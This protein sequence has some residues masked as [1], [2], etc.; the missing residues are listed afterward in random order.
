MVMTLHFHYRGCGFNLW[1]GNEDPTCPAFPTSCE[2][3]NMRNKIK[4]FVF[5][6]NKVDSSPSPFSFVPLSFPSFYSHPEWLCP[7]PVGWSTDVDSPLCMGWGVDMVNALK[8]GAWSWQLWGGC[9]VR[10]RPAWDVR[11]RDHD[12]DV[13]SDGSGREGKS[14]WIQGKW[15]QLQPSRKLDSK[16]SPSDERQSLS[17]V[18]RVYI[19]ERCPKM[20]CGPV[21]AKE[22]VLAPGHGS[23][24]RSAGT[25]VGGGVLRVIGGAYTGCRRPSWVRSKSVLE[26]VQRYQTELSTI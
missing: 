7:I 24:T 22:D 14:K 21:W 20:K 4:H 18:G 3:Q 26:K 12:N 6:I 11:T 15:I 1:S 13:H 19:C 5:N 17:K 23:L 16:C 25:Q 8:Q 10:G 2:K 9:F